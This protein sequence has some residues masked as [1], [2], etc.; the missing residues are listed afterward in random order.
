MA[1]TARRSMP[2]RKITNSVVYSCPSDSDDSDLEDTATKFKQKN[3]NFK[4]VPELASLALPVDILQAYKLN[5]VQNN[6]KRA[7]DTSSAVKQQ[8]HKQELDQM[9]KDILEKQNRKIEEDLERIRMGLSSLDVKFTTLEKELDEEYNQYVVELSERVKNAIQIDKE[10]QAKLKAQKE[11]EAK[12]QREKEQKSL[13]DKQKAEAA[14]KARKEKEEKAR[15]QQAKQSSA[16]VNGIELYAT[17]MKRIEYYREHY[18]PKLQDQK[19]R[20]TVFKERMPIK[21]YLK[22]LQF[23]REVVDQRFKAIRDRLLAARSQSEDAF[24]ILLNYTAKDFLRQARSEISSISWGAYFYARFAMLLGA[25]IPEFM[26][27]LLARLYKR[28]PYMIPNYHDGSDVSIDDIKRLQRYEHVD[29]EKKEFQTI[30]MHYLYQYS[31]VMFF[32]ALV[33]MGQQLGSDPP[34]PHGIE[35]GWLWLARICNVPPRPIT[36]GLIHSFL[37]IAGRGLLRAYPRQAYKIYQVIFND[38]LP[39]TP[40]SRENASP[41]NELHR[42]LEDFFTTGE[43][44]KMPEKAESK[45]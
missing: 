25:A 34:N 22:Q 15:M 16:S 10:K 11:A 3:P 4:K 35:N 43:M 12:A 5:V 14:D 36:P 19:F 42:L 20:S 44:S 27:Y 2:L 30:D 8:A 29:D 28:C 39:A 1:A 38:V 21:R 18:K 7:I 41:L 9:K 37:Q 33:Q 40:K 45:V 23:K 24:H 26:E 6:S 13:E 32:A 17:Y 31:Y